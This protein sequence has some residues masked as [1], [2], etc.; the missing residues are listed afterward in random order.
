MS[1]NLN[2]V[3]LAGNLTRDPEMRQVGADK[4]V[5]NFGLAVNRRW[6]NAAGEQ[7]EEAT[8]VDVEA[9]GRIAEVIGQ[10]LKKGSPAYIDGRLKL[11]TWEDKAG[12]K[13]S[14]LKIVAEQVQFL[15]TRAAAEG[16]T[17]TE[18]ASPSAGVSHNAPARRSAPAKRAADEP[19]PF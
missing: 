6:R 8:F 2:H 3:T 17:S 4:A 7:V 19:A 11:D 13:R 5:V 14:R 16:E 18:S 15:G 1:L 9:W 10:Y 12:Q